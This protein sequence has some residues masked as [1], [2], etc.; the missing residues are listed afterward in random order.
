MTSTTD[1]HSMCR[2][3]KVNERSK[4]EAFLTPVAEHRPGCQNDTAGEVASF[5][6]LPVLCI[7]CR[8]QQ[9]WLEKY[10]AWQNNNSLELPCPGAPRPHICSRGD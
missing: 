7:E 3:C 4:K 10:K 5:A 8:N 2:K 9:D 6:F 1:P